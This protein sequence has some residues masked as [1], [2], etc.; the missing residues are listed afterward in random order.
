MM[1]FRLGQLPG[2]EHDQEQVLT[3]QRLQY[4]GKR[5]LIVASVTGEREAR[6]LTN[7]AANSW[8]SHLICTAACKSGL[9]VRRDAAQVRVDS[10]EHHCSL[11]GGW[12][13]T[14]LPKHVQ[15]LCKW[16]DH[17]CKQLYHRI[18]FNIEGRPHATNLALR[19]ADIVT[20]NAC[21]HSNR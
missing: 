8:E 15:L 11:I 7:L 19:F 21:M 10:F 6:K 18:L 3:G 4:S 13:S 9:P 12:G 17:F 2:L 16:G 1:V 14:P 5:E 20:I